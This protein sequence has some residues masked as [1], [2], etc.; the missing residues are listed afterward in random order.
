MLAA[1]ALLLLVQTPDAR[2]GR[3]DS[4]AG[5]APVPRSLTASAVRAS[6]APVVDGRDT[7]PV[8]RD[9]PIITEF[10]EFDPVEGKEA[11][12]RTEAR[13]AYDSRNFYVF[14]RM[15]DP[16][17]NK[18]LKLLAR[19][20]VRTPS[21]QIKI[22]VDSYHDR[23]SGYEFAV[24]PGGVKRDYAIY[25]DWHEDDTWDAVWDA[26]TTVDSLGWTA[27]FR[28]PLSQIRYPKADAHTFGFAIWRDIDRYKERVS[29][30]LYRRNQAGLASQLG[31]VT[32]IQGLSSPHRFELTPYAVTKNVTLPRGDDFYHPQRLS[33]GLDFKY[34][35][36]SNLTVDGTVNPDFGQ[37]EADPAVLNL[38]AFETFF[39]ERRPFFMEGAGLLS[40]HMNCYGRHGCGSENLFYS[41]RIG[42]SPQLSGRYGDAASATGTTILG[43]AKVTGRTPGGLAIGM[44][45]AVTSRE[46]GTEDRT[47]E[48]LA[49]YSV[50][51]ATQDLRGG[52]TGFGIIGT[53]V[54]R[55]QDEWT[56]DHLRSTAVVGGLDFRH[57]FLKSRFEVRGRMVG[58]RVSGS[59]AAIAAT[60]TSSVHFFQRPD[61]DL[62]YDPARTSL[63]GHAGQLQFAKVGGGIL[64]FETSYQRVSPGFEANDLGFL[65][66]ADW[67]SWATWA[68]LRFNQPG[69]F[70]RRLFWSFTEWND[71]TSGGLP[72]ERAVNTGVSLELPNSAWVHAGGT[73]G[74]LGGVYCDHC[75]RGGPA[76]RTDQTLSSFIAVEGDARL[77]AVPG[78]WLGYGRADGGRTESFN[79]GPSME[80]RVSSR[81]TSSLGF[82]YGWNRDDR[83]WF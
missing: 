25:N 21:D 68:T 57:R 59:E 52:E 63:A 7:D 53:L 36:S 27:E 64:L 69:P 79:L 78:A 22:I 1:A 4:S 66:R 35:L 62:S 56:R 19:R 34:G 29:W 38:S 70:F 83:Q 30:P 55:S 33:G 61:D 49:S 51:R 67:Q 60:Q 50:L 44:I 13:V 6:P 74:G 58:S 77:R 71:W 14:V 17:P 16:E 5:L 39:Q 46:T 26:A 45:E 12:F 43:A 31:E 72:L 20:D 28:I 15:H 40:F 23:R 80:F 8:W 75:A 37:V 82:S 48:P 10:L 32:G 65:R 24:N 3:P 47:I 76:L 42:R 41:R 9:A 2:G 73:W 54:N 18:I 81:F 11:R